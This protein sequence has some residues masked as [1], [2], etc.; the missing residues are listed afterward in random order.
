MAVP[1]RDNPKR[2]R[3][4]A[5]RGGNFDSRPGPD[6]ISYGPTFG[7]RQGMARE[8]M[9]KVLASYDDAQKRHED[10]VGKLAA[11]EASTFDRLFKGYNESKKNDP[12]DDLGATVESDMT[13]YFAEQLKNHMGNSGRRA[14]QTD[15]A[16]AAGITQEQVDSF[17]DAQVSPPPALRD[18]QQLSNPSITPKKGEERIHSGT[19]NKVKLTGETRYGPQGLE[20]EGTF[21][22]KTGWIPE[23]EL[24][25]QEPGPQGLRGLERFYRKA[26]DPLSAFDVTP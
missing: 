20:V 14:N 19:G 4:Y 17:K 23:K 11:G 6:F 7:Q 8:G 9:K 25:P 13:R 1:T 10:V 2:L 18:A 16:Q 24:P 21:K 5:L 26:D 12:K 3:D 22:G 15:S